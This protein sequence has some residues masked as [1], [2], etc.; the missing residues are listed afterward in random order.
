MPTR[1]ISLADLVDRLGVTPR[2]VLNWES[3]SWWKPE[4]VIR[5]RRKKL[6][7]F[8]SIAAAREQDSS[9]RVT[10]VSSRE[11]RQALLHERLEAQTRLDQARADREE[12]KVAQELGLLIPRITAESLLSTVL[13]EIPNHQLDV[14]ESLQQILSPGDVP[15]VK[16]W[17]RERFASFQNRLK[18]KI[19]QA[20]LGLGTVPDL[21]GLAKGAIESGV[22]NED[23]DEDLGGNI[24]R[25]NSR[26]R[27]D[28][29][30]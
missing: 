20:L 1:W 28:A 6:F 22:S 27:K 13:G 19:E 14:L 16:E 10:E 15:K 11:V 2:T 25:K 8:Q 29:R 17:L 26:R 30:S 24:D 9:P 3:Q 7:D 23:Q 21:R 18:A 12:A 5:Q 4:F